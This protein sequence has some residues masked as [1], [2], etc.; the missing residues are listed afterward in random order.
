MGHE[1]KCKRARRTAKRILAYLENPDGA[2]I[3]GLNDESRDRELVRRYVI[4]L[5]RG[6][7][8]L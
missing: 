4:E 3:Q 8:A 6:R 7:L 5:S 1:A 2:P